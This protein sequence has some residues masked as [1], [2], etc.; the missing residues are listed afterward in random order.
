MQVLRF[1][2]IPLLAWVHVHIESLCSGTSTFKW[3][4]HVCDYTSWITYTPQNQDTL[5]IKFFPKASG[6]EIKFLDLYSVPCVFVLC[7]VCH[8]HVHVA[9][10]QSLPPTITAF[11][12]FLQ[13]EPF[14]RLLSH[15]TGLDLAENV[16]RCDVTEEG[17]GQPCSSTSN[18]CREDDG[19]SQEECS[20]SKDEGAVKQET[21]LL[22]GPGKPLQTNCKTHLTHKQ[23]V[24]CL[25][26]HVFRVMSVSSWVVSFQVLTK[27]L[28]VITI[29][30][31][32]HVLLT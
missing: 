2:Y 6:V 12:E 4:H 7:F 5:L 9:E 19:L 17:R 22:N 32:I 18:E 16:I 26:V 3:G 29:Y 21:G 1:S 24:L 8:R 15:L 11:L 23:G 25:Q 27:V 31:V 30:A 28:P 10:K 13:S 14:C 20:N